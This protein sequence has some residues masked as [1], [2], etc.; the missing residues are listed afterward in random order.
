M[1]GYEEYVL[2][3]AFYKLQR[4]RKKTNTTQNGRT[5]SPPRKGGEKVNSKS[6]LVSIT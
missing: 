6:L 4:L 1:H 3:Y 2:M 5:S